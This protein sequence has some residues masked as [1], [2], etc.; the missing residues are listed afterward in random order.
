LMHIS[1]SD[2]HKLKA[3][4]AGERRDLAW[5]AFLLPLLRLSLNLWSFQ[6]VLATL[7]KTAPLSEPNPDAPSSPRLAPSE[8]S[9]LVRMVNVAANKGPAKANCLPRS[10]AIWWLLRRKGVDCELRLG[11]KPREAGIQAH[12]WVEYRG[13][14]L[15]DVPEIAQQFSA[16][17]RVSMDQGKQGI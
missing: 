11:V 10:M 16:F 17:E 3:L 8:I 7:E 2:Y 5:A 6:S 14:V 15:N 9:R 4:G 13:Q 12:A 1:M